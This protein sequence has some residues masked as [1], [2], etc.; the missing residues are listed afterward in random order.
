MAKRFKA[1]LVTNDDGI[2]APGLT[3]LRTVAEAIA[4]DVWVVAPDRDQSGVSH[5]IT[6]H[7]ALRI[8]TRSNRS[9]AVS[10]TPGDCVALG[11]RHIMGDVM[12]DLILSGVN[13]GAN[14]G[15]ETVF[16]G[17]VGAAMT[18]MLLGVPSMALSQAFHDRNAVRWDVA[19]AHA[20]RVINAF[21]GGGWGTEACLN[22][23]FP[24][25]D[26]AMV[27][28]VQLTHQGPGSLRDVTVSSM[29]DPRHIDAHWLRLCHVSADWEE[30]SETY[31]LRQGRIS[32]TPLQFERTSP[33]ILATLRAAVPS[34]A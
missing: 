2:D 13:R 32:V 11:V 19:R 28:P 22:I 33:A 10:G 26:P 18:G 12:P 27:G 34:A 8:H 9:F 30:G 1:I 15:R 31:A 5:A 24:D 4:E 29:V 23:N 17:T 7:S 20:A 6:L 25:V 21:A 3:V 16:S 14:L